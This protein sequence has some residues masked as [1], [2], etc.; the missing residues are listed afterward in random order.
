MANCMPSD[1]AMLQY[2]WCQI[3]LSGVNA[4]T[5]WQDY[6][7]QPD[8]SRK[9][10]IPDSGTGTHLGNTKNNALATRLECTFFE[11]QIKICNLA[12]NLKK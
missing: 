8:Q 11:R 12:E 2:G 1:F 3:Y 9:H 5:E 7:P 10:T 6:V 4:H